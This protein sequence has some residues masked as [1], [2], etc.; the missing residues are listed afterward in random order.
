MY[1]SGKITSTS[2]AVGSL[3]YIYDSN[4]RKNESLLLALC[5]EGEMYSKIP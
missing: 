1:N 5:L 2:F 4:N 3:I